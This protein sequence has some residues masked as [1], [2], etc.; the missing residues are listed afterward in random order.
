MKKIVLFI[1]SI[2]L[3]CG[4][5]YSFSQENTEANPTYQASDNQL[6]AHFLDVGE[7]DAN[8]IEL[9]NGQVMIIDA[10]EKKDSETITNYIDNL[11]I[12]YIDYVVAT[13]PH[14]DHIGSL[15]DII[16][17]YSIGSI[18]MPKISTTS[19]TYENLLTTIDEAD[20]TIN[21]GKKGVV[22]L[23]EDNLKIEILSPT[24]DKY[25]NLNNYSLVIKITYMNTTFLYMGDAEEEVEK[26]L[27]DIEADVLKVGHHG[28]DTSS[29]IEFLAKVKPQYAVISVGD[30]NQY[31][32]PSSTIISR[33]E[34]Y[35]K[36]IYQ[37]SKNGNI[38]ITSDGINLEVQTE[39]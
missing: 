20:L 34:K 18:Y 36:N 9:P 27:E 8:I 2:I 24:M 5:S 12:D 33:L 13:H 39:R 3:L 30:S 31:D 28:S 19:K 37:T 1:I 25:S 17:K 15:A 35:T 14:A 26:Q 16:T 6:I 21:T 22:I 23:D 32:H 29:S 11:N 10:G 7:A 4:C 38:I